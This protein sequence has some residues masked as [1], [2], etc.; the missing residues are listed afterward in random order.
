MDSLESLIDRLRPYPELRSQL[1]LS[2]IYKFIVYTARLRN[3]ISLTHHAK[4]DPSTAP[5]HLSPV[6]QGFLSKVLNL[7]PELVRDC[8]QV[9]KDIVWNEEYVCELLRDPEEG[10]RSYGL[11]LGLGASK[12]LLPSAPITE[13]YHQHPGCSTLRP[14]T[15]LMPTAETLLH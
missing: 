8:W 3:D 10:F 2:Q 11:P 12:I 14:Y 6:M 9:L 5:P 15:V 4:H 7:A 13:S 1:S